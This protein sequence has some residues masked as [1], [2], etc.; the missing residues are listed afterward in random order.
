M[1][2]TRY[3]VTLPRSLCDALSGLASNA[4]PKECCGLLIAN[5]D[6]PISITRF[7]VSS[8]IAADPE[9]TF[10][11]DPQTLI[12]THRSV[13]DR[14]EVIAGCYHSHPNGDLQPSKTDLSRAEEAGFLWLIIAT[15][16]TGVTG[17]GLYRRMPEHSSDT[18]PRHFMRCGISET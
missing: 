16:K 3:A 12:A 8:N 14:G 17:Y 9:K 6:D 5:A 13:R 10:E 4:W 7:V 1:T 2:G 11:I 18:G 15:G